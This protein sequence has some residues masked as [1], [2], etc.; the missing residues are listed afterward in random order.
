MPHAEPPVH[1]LVGFLAEFAPERLAQLQRASPDEPALRPGRV[2]G[3]LSAPLRLRLDVAFSALQAMAAQADGLAHQVSQRLRRSHRWEF[4]AQ[5]VALL[6]S[7]GVLAAVIGDA[8]DRLKL[9]SAL[10]G[11]TGSAVALGV[12][13]MRR[14]LA[15]ADNGLA[16]QHRELATAG[17]SAIELATRLQPHLRSGDD[18][19]D[20]AALA[21]LIDQANT[22]AGR[23]Y[24]LMTQT[25]A[26]VA[27]QVFAPAASTG[28]AA[29][30]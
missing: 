8:G 2:L 6:G 4:V 24:T 18:L 9:A 1:Q 15:G 21:G 28:A 16:A 11:L 22:L 19:D 29:A 23:L 26:P 27:R 30:S 17:G 13:F 7:G 10:I 12:K 14:D 25:G 20:P 5:F 3:A